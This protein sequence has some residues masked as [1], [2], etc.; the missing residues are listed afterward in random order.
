MVRWIPALLAI[1]LTPLCG[2][3]PQAQQQAP[4]AQKQ[5]E[6]KQRHGSKPPAG[7]KEAV[8]PEEDTALAQQQYAFNPLQAQK[9]VQTGKFY[10]TKHNYHAAEMRFREATKWNEGFGEAWLLL[11]ETAE[12]MKDMPAAKEA[13]TKYLDV[14]SDA[15][16]APEIRKKLDKWK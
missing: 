7:A 3:Q 4:P 14:A 1:A 5:D 13:Y 9:E 2:G 15:K 16:N 10:L 12:K 6:L 8:P 11:G